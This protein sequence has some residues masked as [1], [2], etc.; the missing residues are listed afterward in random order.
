M[1]PYILFSDKYNKW[2]NKTKIIFNIDDSDFTE[3]L[4]GMC[5]SLLNEPSWRL[6]T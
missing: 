5:Q 4:K 3:G 1:L 6:S 2:L